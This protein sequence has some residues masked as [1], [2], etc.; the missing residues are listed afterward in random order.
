MKIPIAADRARTTRRI[1]KAPPI[2]PLTV[3][4][5]REGIRKYLNLEEHMTTPTSVT[6]KPC[7]P[8]MDKTYY[9]TAICSGNSRAIRSS[10]IVKYHTGEKFF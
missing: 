4:P 10:L 2:A 1:R 9:N 5:V 8:C 3:V 7:M 6:H